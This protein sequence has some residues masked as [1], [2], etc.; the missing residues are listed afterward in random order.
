MKRLAAAFAF[1]AILSPSRLFGGPAVALVVHASA[2]NTGV[3]FNFTVRAVDVS[4]ATATTYAGTVHFTSSDPAAV[5]PADY[6]FVPGDGGLHTF[7]ATLHGDYTN[8]TITAID[9]GNSSIHGTAGVMVKDPDHVV[10]FG[11]TLPQNPVRE[12]PV[13]MVVKAENQDGQQVASY[14]GTV[15]FTASDPSVELP[16]D[17]TFTAGDAGSHTFS[18]VFHKGYLHSVYVTDI[19]S[20]AS[21]YDE[22]NVQ[23]PDLT[24]TAV[25][26]GPMCPGSS[27]TLTALT[28]ASSPTFLW[29]KRSPGGP[30]NNHSGQ[31]VIVSLTGIWDVHMNDGNGCH[32]VTSTF[33]QLQSPASVSMPHSATGDFTASIA[34]DPNGPY[35]DIVWTVT[36]GTILSGQGTDTITIHP[37][38]ST[39]QVRL[40]V[41]A[42]RSSTSCRQQTNEDIVNTAPPLS[43]EI[44]SATTVCPNA[45]NRTASVPDA[46]AGATYA[47]SVTNGTLVSGQGTPSI[48]FDAP[49]G[50]T[51]Q[52][53]V[54]VQKNSATANGQW[55]VLVKAPTAIVSGGA[56]MCTGDAATIGVTLTGTPPFTLTWSDGL[57]Q[58][59]VNTLTTTRTVMPSESTTYMI[60]SVSEATCTGSAS[61]AATM[62]IVAAPVIVLQPKSVS[63]PSG[64][65]ATLTIAAD[66]AVSYDWYEGLVNDTTKFVGGGPML[67][68]PSLTKPT[69]YWVR[70]SNRCGAVA[71]QPVVVTVAGKRRAAGR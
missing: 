68:T 29:T 18:V 10:W 26:N 44:S 19:S 31:T 17:Y 59:D 52:L 1:A 65:S 43:A 9:T 16:S 6:T 67:K 66:D 39:T 33:V 30:E 22:V 45:T 46:G 41:T 56:E 49:P 42:T 38:P 51:V 54:A 48:T 14:R 50:G 21:G 71:S 11:L 70:V 12:T 23:C 69:S 25:N 47:W 37:D 5:L 57:V 34:G 4:G 64:A 13:S 60:T 55:S 7:T 3:P 40:Y 63:I 2:A 58:P 61:G 62:V 15:H 27:V 8:R 32:V 53:A 35:V 36:N 28:N 20:G 24:L